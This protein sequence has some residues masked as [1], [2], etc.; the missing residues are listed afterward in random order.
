MR[1]AKD[2]GAEWICK[3]GGAA[4]GGIGLW[5]CGFD[6]GRYH[7]PTAVPVASEES[8]EEPDDAA[9]NLAD[10]IVVVVIGS[11]I[12]SRIVR[13]TPNIA[14]RNSAWAH[15]H[16]V[17][18]GSRVY[19]YEADQWASPRPS[20]SYLI[21]DDGDLRSSAEDTKRPAGEYVQLNVCWARPSA[22]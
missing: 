21:V 3:I 14:G 2:G 5:I 10:D 4:E 12:E 13:N 22:G 11:V 7:G 16:N 9:Y 8:R 19:D 18:L 17:F 15:R 6:L 1:N 20:P